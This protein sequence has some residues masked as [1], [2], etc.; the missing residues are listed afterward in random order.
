MEFA[1][2]PDYLDMEEMSFVM[3]STGFIYSKTELL[4]GMIVRARLEKVLQ[5]L[6]RKVFKKDYVDSPDRYRSQLLNKGL[7]PPEDDVSR[8]DITKHDM[9]RIKPH[10]LLAWLH[11][12]GLKPSLPPIHT[13]ILKFRYS[14]M[15]I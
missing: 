15:H 6:K 3:C 8:D 2:D 10:C 13:N 14:T 4:E 11:S 12:D 1:R 9:R 5:Q 7:P